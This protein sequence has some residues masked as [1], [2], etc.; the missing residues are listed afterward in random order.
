MA[1]IEKLQPETDGRPA[2]LEC[3]EVRA[4]G[5]TGT[6]KQE[7]VLQSGG[8]FNAEWNI[9]LE[10]IYSVNGAQL[11]YT[12]NFLHHMAFERSKQ[13]QIEHLENFRQG[14]INGFGFGDMFPETGISFIRII[15]DNSPDDPYINY[16]FEISAD[17]GA[18][19][20]SGMGPGG[21]FI[22]IVMKELALG[23][24]VAFMQTL[25]EE[26]DG[27]L[28]GKHPDPAEL[29]PA[30]S[31]W[32][33]AQQLNR[34]AYDAIATDYQEDYFDNPLLGAIFAEWLAGL[35]R[36]GHILDA[37]CGH[38]DP[39]IPRL[40]KKGLRVTGSDLSGEMLKR[41]RQA[42]PQAVFINTAINELQD[43]AEFDG[44]CS[45][46]SLLY[47]DPVD[48][49]QGIYRLYQALK[50][51]ALL[52]LYAYDLHPG[53]RGNP[54]DVQIGQWMWSWTYSLN[55][56]AAMLE[57]HSRFRVLESRSVLTDE[58]R[59]QA[60]ARWRDAERRRYEELVASLPPGTDVAAPDFANPPANL[61]YPYAILAQ[62]N[63]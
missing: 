34:R 8:N 35:P 37:G 28:A 63:T 45:F 12:R 5:M 58:R 15:T 23:E 43:Q 38:G 2:M 32:P 29:A 20:S 30:S 9:L 22:K 55:E 18:V 57:D 50:P 19:F 52:F 47:L 10:I 36:G 59:E 39:V 25:I 27:C 3:V 56:A 6:D 46:S 44:A 33:F 41:A 13:D 7:F 4:W 62:R 61:P 51:G 42:F 49:R 31:C 40:L 16:K 17:V 14:Q 24:G 1:K 60:N 53:W 21:S 26:I 11:F 48:A 54:Y